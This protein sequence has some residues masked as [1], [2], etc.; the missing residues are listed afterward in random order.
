[1][2]EKQFSPSM[3][4]EGGEGMARAIGEG[5]RG[6]L[7]PANLLTGQLYVDLDFYDD[8]PV[9]PIVQIG[10]YAVLPTVETGLARL[11]EQIAAVLNKLEALPLQESLAKID[12]AVE[13]STRTLEAAEK[14]FGR[15]ETAIAEVRDSLR[16]VRK[17]LEN[18]E[19][20]KLPGEVRETLVALRG[21]LEG[22]GPKSSLYGDLRRTMDELRGAARSIERV[23]QTIEEKPNSLVFGKGLKREVIPRAIPA[24]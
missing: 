9:T 1:M 5:L 6:S 15:S 8:I 4:D 21:S 24:Q 10:D 7:R 12:G 3:R 19:F 20:S 23:A 11:E 17:V 16:A 2:I 13:Q 22:V 14:A 18:P